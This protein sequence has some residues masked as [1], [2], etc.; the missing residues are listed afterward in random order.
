MGCINTYSLSCDGQ[1]QL[2]VNATTAWLLQLTGKQCTKAIC[3]PSQ[4]E[5]C[6]DT[7]TTEVDFCR[8]RPSLTRLDRNKFCE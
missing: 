2:S 1:F 4:A 5:S 3:I 7:L 8:Q 6:L